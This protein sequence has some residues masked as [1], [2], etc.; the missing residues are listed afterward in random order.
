MCVCD[1]AFIGV[2]INAHQLGSFHVLH[3]NVDDLLNRPLFFTY[4]C[5]D[6]KVDQLIVD[7]SNFR[8]NLALARLF[9]KIGSND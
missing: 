9:L 5:C 4:R 3:Q 2:H 6:I 8:L 1:C 7:D